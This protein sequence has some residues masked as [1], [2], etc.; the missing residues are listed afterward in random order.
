MSDHKLLMTL[1]SDSLEKL[2]NLHPESKQHYLSMML[3]L[4]ESFVKD[5]GANCVMLY[6]NNE[7]FSIAAAGV[8]EAETVEMIQEGLEGVFERATAGAPPKEMFN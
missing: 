8:N 7:R 2:Q 3:M 6:R 5:S 4:T 1:L